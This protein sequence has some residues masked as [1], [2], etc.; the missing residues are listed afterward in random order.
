MP[1]AGG[2]MAQRMQEAQSAPPPQPKSHH[3]SSQQD[4][5]A[6]GQS[7]EG[8]GQAQ[9][10]QE[11]AGADAAPAVAYAPHAEHHVPMYTAT[12]QEG[13][14]SSQDGA[15]VPDQLHSPAAAGQGGSGVLQQAATQQPDMQ[16]AGHSSDASDPS[17]FEHWISPQAL[18]LLQ[19]PGLHQPASS[20]R[21]P[22]AV[23]RLLQNPSQVAAFSGGCCS[24]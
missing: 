16:A 11:Q 4:A 22:P 15:G 21:A 20:Q 2:S 13:A 18:Q 9:A 8:P 7:S 14:D 1:A 12:E 19:S 17:G 3:G 5:A 23:E 6:L 24:A 10:A